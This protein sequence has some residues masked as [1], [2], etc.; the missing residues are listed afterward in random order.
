MNKTYHFT[1]DKK[2]GEKAILRIKDSKKKIVYLY[3]KDKLDEKER[4][5]TTTGKFSPIPSMDTRDV[6][7]I[8]GPSG[9]GKSTY[10]LSYMKNFAKVFP[11]SPVFLFSRIADE[12]AYDG[13]Y[14]IRLDELYVSNPLKSDDFPEGS[15]IIFDDVDTIQDKKLLS[16]VL[17]TRSDILEIGRHRRLYVAI[18]SHLLTASLKTREVTNEATEF[19]FFPQ[20]TSKA[21]IK[22]YLHRKQGI[23]GSTI[24]RLLNTNSRWLTVSLRYPRYF[25][26]ET[27][28]EF[29]N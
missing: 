19:T 7:Y 11:D 27:T 5:I 18:T 6:L 1:T 9:S 29:M 28:A 13:C 16:A 8:A 22:D 3:E 24:K 25:F 20:A 23:D 26:T 4:S 15:L 21:V 14:R 2:K 17:H 12:E 10:L